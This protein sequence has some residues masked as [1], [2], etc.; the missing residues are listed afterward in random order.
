M[1]FSLVVLF[2]PVSDYTEFFMISINLGNYHMVPTVMIL[3]FWTDRSE[4]TV[5]T[6]IRLLFYEQS[7]QGLHCLLFYLHVFENTIRF[8]FFV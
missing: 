3:I 6:Q 7:D 4:Q 1:A 5:Q 2:C 8:G